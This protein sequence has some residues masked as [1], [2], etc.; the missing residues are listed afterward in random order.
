MVLL[1]V[2]ICAVLIGTFAAEQVLW[3]GSALMPTFAV[4]MFFTGT[5]IRPAEMW[6]ALRQ[7][8]RL[9]VGL[10]GQFVLMPLLA[11]GCSRLVK[12][13]HLRSGIVLL[14]CMPTAMASNVMTVLLGG[15]VALAVFLTTAGT[16][17]SPLVIILMLPPLVGVSVPVPVLPM[18]WTATCIVVLPVLAG[19][20]ARFRAADTPAWWR[21]TATTM[22]SA[23]IVL[24][25]TIVVAQNRANLD[26]LKLPLATVLLL[27]NISGY[28]TA[29][30]FVKLMH[31]PPSARRTLVIDVGMKNAGMGAVL[32][33]A[34]L[35]ARAS[36][37]SAAYGVIC[38]ITV[39]VALPLR[40]NSADVDQ[41]S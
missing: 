2:I 16:I 39:A 12:D 5:L 24:I 35:G 38:L 7:T 41:R 33:V 25:V 20:A 15:D 30:I 19:I 40:A 11:W 26:S 17:L 4:T 13:P 23:S 3:M 1:L 27:L 14:G 10:V 28:L 36:I 29:F 9:V 18:A 34:H 8:E 37:P 22:A 31:W 32:A 6:T 21:R